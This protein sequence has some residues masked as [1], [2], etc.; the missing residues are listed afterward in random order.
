MSRWSGRHEE[1]PH[2]GITYEK[3][4]TTNCDT[5]RP[6]TYAEIRML[7]WVGSD[8][9][10]TWKYKRR[11][12]VLGL[13]HAIKKSQWQQH[14][15]ECEMAAQFEE[16]QKLLRQMVHQL[17]AEQA[18]LE[19]ILAKESFQEM[20]E[21]EYGDARLPGDP[22]AVEALWALYE[23]RREESTDDIPF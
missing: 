20:L 5:A 10:D 17:P 21:D 13:W 23:K 4:K 7:L 6:Y 3:F 14:E 8:D 18:E 22:K 16:E 12:T 11:N 1:C 9:Y 2:C 15:Y 19:K